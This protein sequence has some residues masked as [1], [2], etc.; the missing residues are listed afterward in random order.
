[1]IKYGLVTGLLLTG[2]GFL[3][4]NEIGSLFIKDQTVQQEFNKVFWIILVMQPL[5]AITFIFDAIFKGMGEMKYLRNVLIFATCFGFIP[6]L[7]LLDYL[8][9]QLYAIWIAFAVWMFF[10]GVF[11][12]FKFYRKFSPLAQKQ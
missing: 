6:T 4:Y 10:R 3:F 11:L 12:Y 9:F 5:C 8:A 7:L 1:M 2:L